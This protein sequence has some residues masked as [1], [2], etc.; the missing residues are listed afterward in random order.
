MHIVGL[1]ARHCAAGRCV[2]GGCELL[3]VLRAVDNPSPG[4][5]EAV[6][7]SSSVNVAATIETPHP[8]ARYGGLILQFTAV[9][10]EEPGAQVP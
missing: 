2:R 4:F 6:L 5:D 9:W 10:M 8:H 1:F 3:P 7:I